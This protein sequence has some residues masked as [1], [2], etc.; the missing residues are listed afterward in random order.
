[1]NFQIFISIIF[2]SFVIYVRTTEVQKARYMT[3]P[4]HD[5]IKQDV[6]LKMTENEELVVTHSEVIDIS[7][8]TLSGSTTLR[9]NDYITHA[10]GILMLSGGLES[11]LSSGS[12]EVV[13]PVIEQTKAINNGHKL[14]GFVILKPFV[15]MKL[16]IRRGEIEFDMNEGFAGNIQEL[17]AKQ[18]EGMNVPED[19]LTTL[20]NK[21]YQPPPDGT[22][23]CIASRD[24]YT[25][26]CVIGMCSCTDNNY[27][28]SYCQLVKYHKKTQSDEENINKVHSNNV[29]F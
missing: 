7:K 25:G 13:V 1:M 14:L 21:D 11:F 24:C 2:A 15:P 4:T 27:T 6:Y 16:S 20:T 26:K 8:N 18:F 9:A 28:G 10:D 3:V 5:I 19:F 29:S 17:Y 23:P 22:G 12:R